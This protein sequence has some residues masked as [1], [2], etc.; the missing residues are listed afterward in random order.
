MNINE[1][2]KLWKKKL[3]DDCEY[4]IGSGCKHDMGEPQCNIKVCPI[5]HKANLRRKP[6]YDFY[7]IG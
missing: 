7:E 1:A 6:I 3:A 4:R 5:L 2:M